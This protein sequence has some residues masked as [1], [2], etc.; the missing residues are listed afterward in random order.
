MLLQ[1]SSCAYFLE[2]SNYFFYFYFPNLNV[3]YIFIAY[4]SCSTGEPV[5]GKK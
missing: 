5:E 3:F 1:L 2:Y 4:S